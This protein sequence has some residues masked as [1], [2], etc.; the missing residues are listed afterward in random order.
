MKSREEAKTRGKPNKFC[1]VAL[2]K[3]ACCEFHLII[4]H[5]GIHWDNSIIHHCLEKKDDF[6][7]EDLIV[8]NKLFI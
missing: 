2:E 6:K 8:S 4:Y 1:F 5:I 7:S 3:Y